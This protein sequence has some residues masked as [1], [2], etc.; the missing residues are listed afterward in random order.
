MVLVQKKSSHSIL[1]HVHLSPTGVGNLA[2][3]ETELV[4][5][6]IKVCAVIGTGAG[7]TVG[8]LTGAIGTSVG[9]ISVG[10]SLGD[11]VGEPL[12]DGVDAFV[13]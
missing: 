11:G 4:G 7:S 1:F 10:E 8:T 13:G 2:P 5:P 6:M 9:R 3:S 12:G